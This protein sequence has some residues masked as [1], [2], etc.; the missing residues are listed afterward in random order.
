MVYFN[1]FGPDIRLYPRR[2][3]RGF[4]LNSI[5]KAQIQAELNPATVSGV[6]IRLVGNVQGAKVVRFCE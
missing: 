6:D 2:E 5:K 1:K 3:R 4:T